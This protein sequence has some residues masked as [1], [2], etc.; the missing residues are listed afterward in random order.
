MIKKLLTKIFE[1]TDNPIFLFSIIA[2]LGMLV[3]LMYSGMALLLT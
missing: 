2:I 1:M 3:G